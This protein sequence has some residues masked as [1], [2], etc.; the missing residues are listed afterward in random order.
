MG[1]LAGRA[2]PVMQAEVA[3]LEAEAGAIR[4]GC[5]E[6]EVEA[7]VALRKQLE[8]LGDKVQAETMR[9][10]RCLDLLRPGRLVRVRQEGLDWGW[11]VRP[12]PT[13][14]HPPVQANP[15]ARAAGL[16]RDGRVACLTVRASPHLHTGGGGGRCAS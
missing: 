14:R 11:G 3:R 8:Q 10:D 12:D 5:T 1:S 15:V 2:V 9:P 16:S 7:Y 6:A 13:T 4:G